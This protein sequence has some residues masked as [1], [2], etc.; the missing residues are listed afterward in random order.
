[1][2]ELV[3]AWN[4]LSVAEDFGNLEITDYMLLDDFVQ[5]GNLYEYLNYYFFFSR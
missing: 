2:D 3:E 4:F 5:T 1:M